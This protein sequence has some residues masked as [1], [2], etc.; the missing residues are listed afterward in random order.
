M[1]KEPIVFLLLLALFILPSCGTTKPP[2]VSQSRELWDWPPDFYLY[3]NA[4]RPVGYRDTLP[5]GAEY[6]GR[7]IFEDVY[8]DA[9][10]DGKMDGPSRAHLTGNLEENGTVYFDEADPEHAYIIY[11]SDPE[12]VVLCDL[13]DG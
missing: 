12:T 7:L 13:V 9:D 1:R 6:V 5:E 4:Y 8:A 11:D 3:D 2:A 10:G